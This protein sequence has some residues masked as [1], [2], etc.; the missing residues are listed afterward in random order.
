MLETPLLDSR[1]WRLWLVPHTHWDREWY[2]PFEDFR[3]HL[4][5]VIDEVIATLE[6]RPE[7]RFTLDG[8]AILLEDYL[9]I[10]PELE[11]RLRALLRAGRIDT[12]PCYTLPDEFLVGAESLVRNLL[13]GRLVCERHGARPAAVGYLPDSFGHPAQLPQV[14]RGF[15]LDT[16]VFSRGLGDERERLGGRFRWVAPDGSEVLAL[17]QPVDYGA[18]TAFGHSGR[19][20]QAEP[21]AN[22]ADRVEQI[23][24]AEAPMR[25]DPAFRDVFLGNGVDHAHLQDDLPEVV[26]DLRARRPHLDVEIAR[27]SDYTAAIA[28]APGD[29]PAFAG[30]LSGGARLNVLRGVNSARMPLK[31]DNERGERALQEAET[32]W[33]LAV[34]SRPGARYPLGELRHAWRELLRNH[35]HDSICGCS[36][37]ETHADMPQRFRASLE[38]ALRLADMALHALGGSGG[39]GDNEAEAHGLEGRYRWSYRPL[40]GGSVRVEDRTGAA[41]FAN[42]LPFAR[43]RLVALDVPDALTAAPGLR[44]GDRPVQVDADGRAWLELEVPGFAA[45]DVALATG[46][47]PPGAPGARALDARTIE[48]A[49]YRVTG[50]DDGTLT[51]EDRRSGAVVRGLHRLEDVADRGDS[52]TFCPVDGDGPVGAG[53]PTQVRVTAAGPVLRRARAGDRADA[54]RGAGRGPRRARRRRGRLP[55]D[56]ARAAGGRRGAAGVRDHGRQPRPRPPPARALHDP[57]GARARARRGP[58]RRGPAPAPAGVEW[59]LGRAA[60][61]HQPHARRRC[62]GR[63]GAVHDRPARVRGHRGGR[64]GLTLLRCVGWL[65]RGDLGTRRGHAGPELPVP[66]PQCLGA[67]ASPTRGPGRA[68]RRGAATRLAGPPLRLRGRPPGRRAGAAGAGAGRRRRHRPEGCRGRRRRRAARLQSRARARRGAARDEGGAGALR[69]GRDAARARPGDGHPAARRGRRLPAQA[70][71]GSAWT[72]RAAPGRWCST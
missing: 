21:G 10:R 25:A 7:Y 9:E 63:R 58:L 47:A 22:A 70:A 1:P 64:A 48:N 33:A 72:T 8:Q 24:R 34:L 16:F 65:S 31:Q 6:A 43:R 57:G 45:R 19:S 12:G 51:V 32:L 49:R 66:G 5:E 36:V 42:V 35:P 71:T 54:S 23:L 52:Y 18:A 39:P 56:D 37:D 55:A 38:I 62:H 41:S 26:A 40:P 4:V 13:H 30:E 14:L 53:A 44:A 11:D 61:R 69:P 29:L 15:G 60:A 28:R 46:S 67:T 68:R 50:H 20:E 3:I 59:H 2:L 27:L 17:P